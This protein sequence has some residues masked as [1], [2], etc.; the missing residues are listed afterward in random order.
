M[1]V[2]WLVMSLEG[3]TVTPFQMDDPRALTHLSN[4][5]TFL[6]ALY[7]PH[8][9][10]IFPVSAL[11]CCINTSTWPYQYRLHGFGAVVKILNLLSQ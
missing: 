2:W 1:S 9:A 6:S 11:S 3:A 5:S 4:P 7:N 8:R 10:P